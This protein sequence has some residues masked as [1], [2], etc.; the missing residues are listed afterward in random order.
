MEEICRS[1]PKL[2]AVL[3]RERHVSCW[4][5]SFLYKK[6]TTIES[7]QFSESMESMEITLGGKWM[8]SENGREMEWNGMKENGYNKLALMSK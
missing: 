8:K 4:L 1:P 2:P 7:R 5:P 3:Q 6:T